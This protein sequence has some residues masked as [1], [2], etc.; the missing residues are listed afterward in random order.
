M[1]EYGGSIDILVSSIP[2]ELG[3]V[4]DEALGLALLAREKMPDSVNISDT[5]GCIYYKRAAYRSA[6]ELLE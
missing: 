5:L 1:K 3:L 4:L 2:P 6:I